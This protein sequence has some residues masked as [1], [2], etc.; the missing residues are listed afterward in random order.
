ML[1]VRGEGEQRALPIPDCRPS[2]LHWLR[3][4]HVVF[5]SGAEAPKG[6]LDHFRDL[7]EW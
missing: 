3:C 2:A 7:L 5:G 1:C 6:R 4:P